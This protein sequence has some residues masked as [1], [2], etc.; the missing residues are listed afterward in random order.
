MAGDAGVTDRVLGI[1]VAEVVL[2]EPQIVAAVGEGEAARVAQHVRVD[3]LA[4]HLSPTRVNEQPGQLVYALRD[5]VCAATELGVGNAMMRHVAP[6][7]WEHLSLTGGFTGG[8][9]WS[10]EG[11]LTPGKL[12]PLRTKASLL[13]A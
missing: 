1:A 12:R 4:R 6:L 2:D 10:V 5:S 13:A 7:G 9:A 3:R 11:Q 8:Y